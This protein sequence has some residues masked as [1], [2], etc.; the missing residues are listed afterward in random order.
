VDELSID[1]NIVAVSGELVN[2]NDFVGE[3]ASL[4]NEGIANA[5]WASVMD[6]GYTAEETM[7][8]MLAALAGKL[9]GAAG[10]TINIRDVNDTK[11]RITATVDENGNRLTV[12][13]DG[14]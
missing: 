14:S 9:S 6:A 1:S 2:I 3:A 12:T 11:N 10:T 13:L 5:V 4:T 8:I 7:K